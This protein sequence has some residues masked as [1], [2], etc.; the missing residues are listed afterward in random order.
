MDGNKAHK[1]KESQISKW[2]K[3]KGMAAIDHPH[4]SI[5]LPV[6]FYSDVLNVSPSHLKYRR[7]PCLSTRLLQK[8]ALRLIEPLTH[9]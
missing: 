7:Y 2:A 5:H 6:P 9:R 3:N 4:C 1:G 8:K